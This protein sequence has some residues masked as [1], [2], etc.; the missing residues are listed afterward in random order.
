MKKVIIMILGLILVGYMAFT[1]IQ[2][3]KRAVETLTIRTLE[4]V[5][6]KVKPARYD[7]QEAIQSFI[8]AKWE[9]QR[10]IK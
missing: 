9:A 7:T 1:F 3:E 4:A 10:T 8:D 6:L 2:V 5:P